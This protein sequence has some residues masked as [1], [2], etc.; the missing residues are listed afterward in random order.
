MTAYLIEVSFGPVQ[1]FIASA[2]RS[3]DLWAGSYILSE[4]ARAAGNSLIESGAKLIYPAESRVRKEDRNE[5]SNL[6]NMLLVRLPDADEKKAGEAAT[7]AIA[8]GKDKLKKFGIDALEEWEKA[9]I[10]LR[11]DLF[12]LQVKDALEGYAAWARID[13]YTVS[14]QCLKTTFAAR[15]NTRDFAF[16]SPVGSPWAGM[17]KNSFDGL[18]ESVLPEGITEKQRRRFGL[19]VN[20]Q[21]DALGA[22]KRS[23]LG[24]MREKFTALTRMAAH[25]W[26]K[27]LSE[28]ELKTLGEAYKPLVGLYLA[29]RANGNENAYENF[30][31][32]AA[33]LYPERLEREKKDAQSGL[34]AVEALKKFEQA[35][36]PIW[37]AHG[38]PCPYAVLVV[39]DGDRMGK[40]VDA[41]KIKEDHEAIT[42]AVASFADQVPDIARNHGGHSV[43]NGGEDLTVMFPLSGV[44]EGAR[45]LFKAFDDSMREIAKRLLGDKFETERPTLRVGA[46]IC[47]VMEPLGM[48]RRW[49]DAA[50]K[51]AK[52]EA[53]TDGQGNALGLVLHI[54]AGHEI[55]S[56]IS[57][58]DAPAFDL[59]GEW[60][61]AYEKNIFPG[62]LAYDCRS[63]ALNSEARGLPYGV[64]E[65]E[66]SRLLDRARDSAGS[67]E[68]SADLR[69]KLERRRKELRNAETDPSGLK[70]LGDELILAR[71]LSAKTAK[72]IYAL[73]GDG[74]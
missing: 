22:I 44:V 14:Y 32:D 13:S 4:V 40:F 21:L 67:K 72:D 48:I 16:M 46:A 42:Q 29:T 53:G 28:K 25:G 31:Y 71:W 63:I 55:S 37:N 27:E 11:D 30:P 39:A 8:A 24:G 64:A 62:R 65:A 52:G 73:G 56:R 57:F 70:R 19:S 15:K 35:I 36:E 5:D 69:G 60:Q 47:H 38:R 20:E 59:L 61:S 49:A 43:F 26:L 18:R 12:G 74:R 54:R 68:I 1:G 3:R 66:F 51:F 9:G 6:S 23:R 33:L 45:A 17:P 41:A 2:R 50:E 34:D 58:G 10:S 7:K